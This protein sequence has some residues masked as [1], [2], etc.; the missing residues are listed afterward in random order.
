LARLAYAA[1]IAESSAES[2]FGK[3]WDM[4][5]FLSV[6]SLIIGGVYTANMS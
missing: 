5:G 6:G 3:V 4:E 2:S 1:A